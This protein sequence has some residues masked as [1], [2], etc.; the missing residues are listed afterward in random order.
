MVFSEENGTITQERVFDVYS[1]ESE[2]KFDILLSLAE[3]KEGNIWVGTSRGPVIFYASEEIFDIDKVQGNQPII[4]RNDG[5][6]FGS[7]LLSS[8]QIN[9]IAVDGA[10]RKWLATEKTGVY[11]VSPNGQKEIYH[12]T[13]ENSPLLSNSVQSI[14]INDK[15]GEVFFGTD[16]GIIGF[17]AGATEGGDDFGDVYVFPNPVRETFRGDI[18]ITGLARDVNVKVTDI[19]GNIVF[20]TKALGGQAIWNG[21]N[22]R[23]DRVHT[24]VY[25]VFCTSEDGSKTHVTKLLF[26]H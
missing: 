7:L 20:E 10:D 12:F 4:P 26:I 5:T 19:A 1:R 15:T 6:T 2:Q 21:R 18:T 23:G 14:G 24:G 3:D 8:E 25:L 13:A 22:F 11:L 9:D 17:R 16:K